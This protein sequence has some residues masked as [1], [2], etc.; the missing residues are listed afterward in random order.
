VR[1]R[2]RRGIA[3]GILGIVA[4][5][6]LGAAFGL[7]MV[8][9]GLIDS[10]VAAVSVATGTPGHATSAPSLPGASPGASA[11]PGLSSAS[12]GAPATPGPAASPGY[13]RAGPGASPIAPPLAV[14]LPMPA[15]ADCLGCHTTAAGGVGT[16][17]VPPI[18]HPL[19]GWTSCTSC[20]ANDSLVKTAPGHSGIHADQCLVCHTATTPAAVDRPHSA[21][22]DV[23]CLSCHGKTAPLP[24]SMKNR[25]ETTCW[26]CH[27][28]AAVQAPS[29]PHPTPADGICLT[30]HSAGRLG[31]LPAD[32]AD[33]TNG[34]CSACHGPAA[35]QPPKA[36]HDLASRAGMCAFC[37]LAGAPSN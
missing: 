11:V 26:L 25:S 2:R 9:S 37:H 29:Y 6:V 8:S 22:Q 23:P 32:H 17:S 16:A 1:G 30:C 7:G 4:A 27:P 31:A 28:A 20:H 13:T 12:P 18:G 14:T 15:G 35:S 33:R 5:V 3:L 34:Q 36:P 19:A 21:R 24:D 10:L